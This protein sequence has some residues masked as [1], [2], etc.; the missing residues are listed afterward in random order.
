MHHYLDPHTVAIERERRTCTIIPTL[1]MR[2]L[3]LKRFKSRVTW[4]SKF[5]HS[6]DEWYTG[7]WICSMSICITRG[8]SYQWEVLTLPKTCLSAAKWVK[9]S[10]V[11]LILPGNSDSHWIWE[12]L[13]YYAENWLVNPEAV[14]ALC[15]RLL[16]TEPVKEVC[17]FYI[18]NPSPVC[19]AISSF[20]VQVSDLLISLGLYRSLA[21]FVPDF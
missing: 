17:I 13:G 11:W 2:K 18:H 9:P 15:L 19:N 7:F 8:T 4:W 10:S 14:Q 3:K 5:A 6:S 1:Q 21:S 20:G 12:S 16:W